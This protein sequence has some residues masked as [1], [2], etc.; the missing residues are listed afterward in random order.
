MTEVGLFDING[1]EE[2]EG[3]QTLESHTRRFRFEKAGG[4]LDRF[5]NPVV[6]DKPRHKVG[7]EEEMEGMLVA[8]LH[9]RMANGEND[10]S[11]S[12][13]DKEVSEELGME[14]LNNE[15]HEV[16]E[17]SRDYRKVA[18]NLPPQ[19]WLSNR[20]PTTASPTLVSTQPP[21]KGT[22]FP[23]FEELNSEGLQSQTTP[24]E[25][26]EEVTLEPAT[27]HSK[28]REPVH[29]HKSTTYTLINMTES[30]GSKNRKEGTA[31]RNKSLPAP[32]HVTK[33]SVEVQLA[34][35]VA[36]SVKQVRERLTSEE[37]NADKL[38]EKKQ[39]KENRTQMPAKTKGV[40]A[41]THFPYF[42]DDYC[43]P[44]CACYGR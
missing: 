21:S 27:T 10:F 26:T 16:A 35:V 28:S 29:T 5:K 12:R 42:L 3:T 4:T 13:E 15:K 19:T 20:K 37:K 40:A 2:V 18:T 8:G 11:Q 38:K 24:K 25:T 22:S 36:S 23:P 30:A 39:K 33:D 32:P 34:A 44:E 6:T 31:I 43:P 9:L 41:P 7:E 14:T 1:T 17:Q